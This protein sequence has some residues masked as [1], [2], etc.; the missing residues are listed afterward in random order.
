MIYLILSI[1]SSSSLLVFFKLFEKYKVNAPQAIAVNYFVAA[2][3]G[4]MMMEDRL[5]LGSS[6]QNLIL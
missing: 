2:I 5:Q 3:V 1:V 4:Y 6:N